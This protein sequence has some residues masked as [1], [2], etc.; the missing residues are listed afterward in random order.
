[1]KRTIACLAIIVACLPFVGCAE[2]DYERQLP[3]GMYALR[4]I[5]DST[6]IPDFSY[7][8]QNTAGLR[9]A[10]QN[11]LNYLS[12]PSSQKM[13]PCNEITHEQAVASLKQFLYLID[14]TKNPFTLNHLIRQQ[15]DVY[16]SIGCDDKGT[17]LFTGY[18]TPILEAS[19]TQSEK[20][21]FPLYKVPA[22]L[23]KGPDGSPTK[24]YPDR[25]TI[26]SQKLYAGSELVWLTSA[27]ESY[28]AHIQGS[29][30]LKMADGKEMT[31]GY[32]ANNG[33][34]YKSIRAELV[35][36]K[37]IKKR[38]GLPQMMD[39]FKKNPE[40][41][42]EY[43]YR[44]PRYIFFGVV[45]DGRPRGCINEPVIPMRSIAT[46]KAIF[47]AGS[48]TFVWT[49]LPYNNGRKIRT[50]PYM[51]FALDQDAGG[52]IRAPGRCDIYMGTG[53]NAGALS[54]RTMNEG[55]LYYLFLKPEYMPK[56]E[57][58]KKDA[59]KS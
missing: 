35:A 2:L 57:D 48:L 44:N 22:D 3:P 15:F 30:R 10:I 24:S 34:D 7:A 13:F 4:K 41:V 42:D 53:E 51:G 16:M 25:R 32:A 26:D 43:V 18:Y 39:F 56:K 6:Q 50:R 9:E 45:E 36:E 23:E 11:S 19:S 58:A 8:C 21:N 14:T 1:M 59:K 29:A 33:H 31:V 47:P 40:Q 17:V 46:N 12:K 52:A 20:F 49:E 5:T 54:G 27:F 38:A 37:K 28:V 55:R